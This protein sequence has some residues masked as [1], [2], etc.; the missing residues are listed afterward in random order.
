LSLRSNIAIEEIIAQLKGIRG[1]DVSF[2]EEGM[3]FSLPDAVAKV[4]EKH[5][6]RG[7]KQLAM[8]LPQNNSLLAKTSESV[9]LTQMETVVE[10][11]IAVNVRCGLHIHASHPTRRIDALSLIIKTANESVRVGR[12]RRAYCQWQGAI[13]PHYCACNQ[14]EDNHVEFRWFN[15]AI[16]FRYLCK[17]VRLVNYYC[18]LVAGDTELG[19]SFL[20]GHGQPA[21][22]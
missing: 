3:V 2:S 11:K 18:G 10:E 21:L 19:K 13:N 5:I 7:V 4:L 20:P 14:R 8:D 22:V 16:D 12:K 9:Q 1:P 6:K 17:M 15:A